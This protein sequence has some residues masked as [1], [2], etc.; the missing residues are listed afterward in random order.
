ME[1]QE[2]VALIKKGNMMGFDHIY[3]EY[4]GR[5]YG[6]LIRMVGKPSEAED[7]TSEVFFRFYKGIGKYKDRG[8]LSSFIY[9]IAHNAAM[10]YFRKSKRIILSYDDNIQSSKEEKEE[11][12]Y[13]E[14]EK[15]MLKAGMSRLSAK[16]RE[17]LIM[18]YISG[19]SI[20]EIAGSLGKSVTAVKV[21]LKRARDRLKIEVPV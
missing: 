20:K 17:L 13:S 18:F 10:D 21:S 3:K 5:I 6:Y 15:M 12:P 11:S 4:S 19:L 16:D 2:A 1:E 7:L 9:R 14:E 8:M